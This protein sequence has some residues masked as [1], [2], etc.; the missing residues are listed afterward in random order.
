MGVL[1]WWRSVRRRT[2]KT[3]DFWEHQAAEFL[4]QKG[5][6]LLFKNYRC[7]AGEVDLVMQSGKDMIVFVEVRYRKHDQW[8]NALESVG[9][10]KQQKVIRAA[11]HLMTKKKWH[12]RYHARFDVVAIQGDHESHTIDWIEHA[13]Y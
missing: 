9:K 4:T 10:Q 6:K 11:N 13:F 8:A 3:G 2:I 7:T 5:L 12:N 1:H